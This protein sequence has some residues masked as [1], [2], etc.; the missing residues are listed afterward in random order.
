M[1]AES[2]EPGELAA[3]GVV[4]GSW[5]PRG[6][7]AERGVRERLLGSRE[8][9]WVFGLTSGLNSHTLTPLLAATM[10]FWLIWRDITEAQHSSTCKQ[11]PAWIGAVIVITSLFIKVSVVV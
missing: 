4:G 7:L 1:E 10:R 2:L 5:S 11:R 9:V 3:I 6:G 8:M